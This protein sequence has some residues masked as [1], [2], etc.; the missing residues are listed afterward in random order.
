M[1]VKPLLLLTVL[2]VCPPGIQASTMDELQSLWN[3]KG[4]GAAAPETKTE[5]PA[6]AP[7]A[8]T[9]T[10][11]RQPVWLRLSNGQQANLAEWK[12]VLFMQGSCPY[13]H[14]FDPMLKSLSERVG[15]GVMAYTI[16][17]HGDEAYPEALPV[18]ADVMRT[19]FPNLPVA[20][21]TTF[22][23]NVNTLEALP[24]LQGATD[25]QG[26]MARLDTVLQMRQGG[27]AL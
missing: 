24:L 22:L 6:S 10:P 19:F 11:S 23:V 1:K 21:P 3:P 18:P 25:E 12:V 9:A 14:K 7:T 8:V 20:T 15:F 2:C 27:R 17:G 26:F 4:L 16:D 5:T 13:C